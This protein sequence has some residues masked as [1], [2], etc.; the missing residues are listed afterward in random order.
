MSGGGLQKGTGFVN[1]KA[2]VLERAGR[3]GWE[4]TLTRFS[5]A[6]A[7]AIVVALPVAW[8]DNRLYAQLLRAVD[9]S[10]GKNDGGMP[11][12]IGRF[13]AE[14]DVNVF[15]RAFLRFANPAFVVE[16]GGA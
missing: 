3:A 16:K 14:R 8:Y 12:A 6:D 2:F 1:I 9:P 13:N 5:D 11:V 4:K 7:R 10:I 15:H